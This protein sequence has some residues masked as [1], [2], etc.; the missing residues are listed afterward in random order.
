MLYRGAD[1]VRDVEFVIFDEVHYVNDSERGVV[2]EEVIIMLPPSITIIM[3][4]ATIPNTMEFSDWVG[5]TK[6]KPIYVI[7]TLKRPVPLEHFLYVKKEPTLIVDSSRS[8]SD[9]GYK[10]ALIQT[11][12]ECSGAVGRA[13]VT[14]KVSYDG[15]N[16][17]S[18]QEKNLWIEVCYMLKKKSLLPA[19]IFTFS[20]RK[21]EENADSMSSIDFNSPGEKS[22]VHIF[23]ESSLCRLKGTDSQLPQ[24]L[25]MKELLS[26]GIGVHH[27]GLL[28]IMKE[29]VEILFCRGFI[30]VLF[31]T[32]TFAMGV[33]MPARTA[34][35][36]S[37][38][39]HDGSGF[40]TLLPGEYTQMAG[41]AGRRGLDN[42]GVVMIVCGD[43]VPAEITLRTMILGLPTKLISQFRLTYNMI[44]NLLRVQALRMED[45]MKKSFSENA[46][47][48]KL[49]LDQ[50]EIEE[51]EAD[52][53][54]LENLE[55]VIC[56]QD[57]AE[58]YNA[59]TSIMA[60]AA[61]YFNW[62]VN[63]SKQASKYFDPGRVVVINCP[64]YRNVLA[65]VLKVHIDADS[66]KILCFVLKDESAK[67]DLP[68]PMNHLNTRSE[69]SSQVLY[70]LILADSSEI[71]WIT[72]EKLKIEFAVS[73]ISLIL[74]HPN[75]LD[76]LKSKLL[77][78][79]MT[80]LKDC[81]LEIELP[82]SK[83]LEIDE[84]RCLR[85]SLIKEI[86]TMQ[87][88][89]CPDLVRH[90]QHFHER[91]IL[92]EK[93]A[94]LRFRQT[95]S[96]MLLLPEYQSRVAVL[97]TLNYIDEHSAVQLKGRV[98]CEIN[99]TDELLTT[100]LLFNNTF[101]SL[102]SAEIVALLSCMVFQEK[103]A[104]P[105]KLNAR[106]QQGQDQILNLAKELVTIQR[107]HGVNVAMDQ[108]LGGLKFGLVQVVHEWAL[109][110]PF[111]E[112]TELTD[113]LE[114][115]IVRCIVRLDETCRELRSA[116]KLMGD[117]SLHRKMEEAS[118]MIKRDICFASSLYY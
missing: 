89:R 67:N 88:N 9:M 23:L 74:Y 73:G 86:K 60:N 63:E 105:P 4:S 8:F 43:E 114:G 27:S 2:W 6:Q 28:P 104:A 29:A 57:L 94:E 80:K 5:R 68:F 115:S 33:N 91:Q 45:M 65:I 76:L 36:S 92:V 71:L 75:D 21:C 37:I 55:C 106:L 22:A 50:L 108:V 20:K 25:R 117:P 41:R 3:L 56:D 38:R 64:F 66:R 49:P 107:E 14:S 34:V 15:L 58:F 16:R 24:I 98:A 1:L 62:L 11:K 100:E 10:Q 32:E 112:I 12:K 78:L 19:V 96:N 13:A 47:Q 110:K 30:K 46:A 85:Y 54:Q 69:K 53:T 109:G 70:D 102:E 48:R 99:T 17:G 7:S 103:N 111:K 83:T 51:K 87:C 90:F 116:A 52:L 95:D 61:G 118:N 35:F 81:Y 72:K 93:L 42:T 113:V 18:K 84:K 82:T 39:K 26:R 77:D 79:V 40:R 31:A 97:K 44:L 59:C 101:S